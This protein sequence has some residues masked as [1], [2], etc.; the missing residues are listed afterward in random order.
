MVHVTRTGSHPTLRR[1]ASCPANL[2]QTLSG[3][4]VVLLLAASHHLFALAL[5]T[6]VTCIAT[7]QEV[8][9]PRE[10]AILFRKIEVPAEYRITRDG[11]TFAG[12]VRIGDLNGDG[13]CDLLVYRCNHGAPSG[14]HRGGLKPAFIGAFETDGKPLW[15]VGEGGS[16]PSRPMS[17]AVHEMTGDGAA[18]VVCFWHRPQAN[19]KSDW[20]SLS[21]VVVQVRDG[22]S[23]KVV[24]EAA[25]YS[26]TSRRLKDPQGSN[27]VH[28]RIL[29]A[30]FRGTEIPRDIIVKLGDTYVALDEHLQTL[31]TYTTPWVKYSACP[32][33]IPAVGDIDS[34]G[35]DEVNG[36][37]FVLDEDGS[38]LWEKQLGR[39]MDSVVVT[40]WDRGNVRAICSGFGHVVAADGRVLLSL[41]KQEVPH[42]QEVRVADFRDDLHGP[43]MVIRSRGHKSDTILVSSESGAIVERLKLNDSPTNVGMEPVHW[44]GA[45]G[46]ALL[47]NGGWLWDFQTREGNPLPGLPPP[48]G[49]E[50]HRMGFFHAIAANVCGDAREELVLWDPTAP[51]VY[52]YTSRPFDAGAF[53]GYVAGPR[54]YNPRLMD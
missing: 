23:G 9:E 44:H 13:D 29:I 36:G 48:N 35:R 10:D 21:D 16:H 17:I 46:R 11:H 40:A 1:W 34:D 33:Y 7:A 28:Q 2:V 8:A 20:R 45:D 5:L 27:W 14:A 32:A 38:P 4:A 30:N 49:G 31:W 53:R 47:Y 25:P 24:R 15:H 19:S 54:Q 18:D 3:A 26:V 51:R 22:R 41:G 43:E 12:D 39:N 50:V 6:T 42:G 52:V 37:Y